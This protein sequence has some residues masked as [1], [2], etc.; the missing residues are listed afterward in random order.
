MKNSG[1]FEKARMNSILIPTA[2]AVIAA[3]LV[4]FAVFSAAYFG[5]FVSA[6]GQGEESLKTSFD[7]PEE[8][9]YDY[10]IK[11][12]NENPQSNVGIYIYTFK[13]KKGG[14]EYKVTVERTNAAYA[15]LRD[16]RC[17]LYK[18]DICISSSTLAENIE[19]SEKRSVTLSGNEQTQD[20]DA[21]IF[22]ITWEDEQG[23]TASKYTVKKL[24]R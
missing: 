24:G 7:E 10:K 22:Y 6:E 23:K 18:D 17:M 14:V 16:V 3:A 13:E 21:V 19:L 1:I 5:A 9:A 20:A 12:V 4:L 11:T 15:L 8:P 2:G